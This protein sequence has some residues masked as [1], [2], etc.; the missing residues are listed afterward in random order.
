MIVPNWLGVYAYWEASFFEAAQNLSPSWGMS[1]SG[2]W[3]MFRFGGLFA[4]ECIWRGSGL[5]SASALDSPL[6]LS[7]PGAEVRGRVANFFFYRAE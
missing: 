5:V 2:R 6:A 1:P 4:P 3:G 7:R